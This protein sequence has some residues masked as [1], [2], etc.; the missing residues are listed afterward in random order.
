MT[1]IGKW[2]NWEMLRGLSQQGPGAGDE[3]SFSLKNKGNA[4]RC[5]RFTHSEK[6]DV[7]VWVA[8]TEY[9]SLSDNNHLFLTVLE[10]RNVG[11]ECRHGWVFGE[12]SCPALGFSSGSVVKNL[13]TM[14]KTQ[15]WSLGQEDPLEESM[16][17]HS[18]ILAVKTPWTEEPGRLQSIGLERVRHNWSD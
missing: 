6:K 16:A 9:H 4:W 3:V 14:Q 11:S 12:G 2:Q 17:T 18:S 1:T 7:L 15:V 10:A 13:P 5:I 8:V